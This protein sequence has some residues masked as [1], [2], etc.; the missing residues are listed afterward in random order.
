LDEKTVSAVSIDTFK[1]QEQTVQYI[2]VQDELLHG[3]AVFPTYNSHLGRDY[4]VPGA[5][6]ETDM[7]FDFAWALP[8]TKCRCH[9]M[10]PRASP[11]VTGRHRAWPLLCKPA[12]SL[13]AVG[14]CHRYAMPVITVH[15]TGVLGSVNGCLLS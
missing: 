2:T 9:R 10:S 14:L 7:G 1:P 6:T 15:C 3:H 4:L 13:V 11:Y 5:Y 8:V 12:A